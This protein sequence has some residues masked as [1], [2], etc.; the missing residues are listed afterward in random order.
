MKPFFL[1]PIAL[2]VL[3]SC[4][5]EVVAHCPTSED[6]ETGVIFAQDDQYVSTYR[7]L[8]DGRIEG[9]EQSPDR[10]ADKRIVLY[11]G[12]VFE[13]ITVG[14]IEAPEMVYSHHYYEPIE[15]VFS[16]QAGTEF[17]INY[18]PCMNDNCGSGGTLTFHFEG[19]TTAEL[20]GCEYRMVEGVIETL[21]SGDGH[22]FHEFG[23]LPDLGVKIYEY[24]VT[25]DGQR[26]GGG[27]EYNR[28]ETP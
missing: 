4:D 11:R 20:S 8:P 12:L 23:Y 7:S 13:G 2:A 24:E 26:L 10:R 18:S 1:I 15:D 6:M 17:S 25:E 9:L 28:I 3:V 19:E 16:D 14:D 5:D 22:Y 21:R 27:Y